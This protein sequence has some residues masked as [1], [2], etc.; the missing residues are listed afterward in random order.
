MSYALQ[1]FLI[2]FI[3]LVTLVWKIKTAIAAEKASPSKNP[4]NEPGNLPAMQLRNSRHHSKVFVFLLIPTVVFSQNEFYNT[5]ATV[6][7]QQGAL[8]HVQGTLNNNT[9][10]NNSTGVFIN[11]GII[12]LDGDFSSA[13]GTTF[14][15]DPGI[16]S[17]DRVVKFTGS[18]A[19]H[20]KGAA[21]TFYNLVLDKQSASDVVM[22]QTPVTVTGSLV[23]N[24]ATTYPALYSGGVT[25]TTY[26]PSITTGIINYGLGGLLQTYDGSGNEYLLDVKNAGTDAINGYAALAIN[27]NPTTAYII[28]K[29]S[30]GSTGGGLQRA[31]GQAAS[32]VFPIG[33]A[34][35]GFNAVQYNF[36]SVPGGNSTV[37]GKFCDYETS[38]SGGYTG[39]I[40]VACVGC[41]GNY[42]APDNEGYNYYFTNDACTGRP[43]WF[44]LDGQDIKH[45]Y[46]TFTSSNSS[47][48]QY[49]I[50]AFPNHITGPAS[51]SLETWRVLKYDDAGH[52]YGYD[53]SQQDW[54]NQIV[55]QAS[56]PE[57]LL[58]WSLNT[59]CYT[60]SGIPGGKYT[61]FSEFSLDKSN[62]S[63]ALPVTLIGLK[64]YAVNNTYIQ[65]QWTT[66][67]EINNKGF[68]VQRS[69]DG[70]NFIDL[71]WVEGHDN[72]TQNITY[73]YNDN[74]VTAGV[75]FYY[76]L[77]QTDNN[78]HMTPTDMVQ[79]ELTGRTVFVVG[80][81][82]PNPATDHSGLN[83]TASQ[84]QNISLKIYDMIGQQ[85]ATQNYALTPGDN[86]ISFNTQL[87][88][89]GTYT[90]VI[91]AGDDLYSRKLVITK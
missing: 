58:T 64:A 46:W 61:G 30:S 82:L 83:I 88:T 15:T 10:V 27:E 35:H 43:Q 34:L 51:L 1:L 2:L 54:T 14:Q 33:T 42:V 66:A 67:L 56:S 4:G 6:C 73:D 37:K 62:S 78:G 89:S 9:D 55:S 32:Y 63:N 87:M 75:N 91:A 31:I 13:T 12:E 18:G 26:N 72:S 49:S 57:D 47:A 21:A 70:V 3:A 8:L 86:A 65:V 52:T 16:N 24:S 23:F 90:A 79:A 40:D 41:S 80:N 84:A 77:L 53:P 19:Q 50:E 5:G 68:T 74:E 69:T 60:G 85:I 20:I 11:N 7:V 44:I 28:T 36:T 81:P 76:R 48:F 25:T 71:G 29:G 59:G 45:G 17:T 22:M 39:T 38:A